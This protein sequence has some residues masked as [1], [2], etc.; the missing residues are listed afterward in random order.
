MLLQ[1]ADA[2]ESLAVGRAE[3]LVAR[4]HRPRPVRAPVAH[5]GRGEAGREARGRLPS[6]DPVED[7][8]QSLRARVA[9]HPRQRLDR[10]IRLLPRAAVTHLGRNLSKAAARRRISRRLAA[11]CRAQPL[12]EVLDPPE[13]LRLEARIRKELDALESRLLLLL[14]VRA[15]EAP[16]LCELL[17]GARVLEASTE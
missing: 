2:R 17:K 9:A 4:G 7:L 10:E 14:L 12:S 13:A 1:P 3:E 8:E 11:R 5:R 16:E 15:D 6:K